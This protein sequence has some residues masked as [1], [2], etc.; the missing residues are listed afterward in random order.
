[1]QETYGGEFD[2]T[3]KTRLESGHQLFKIDID[4]AWKGLSLDFPL[5]SDR[6]ENICGAIT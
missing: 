5:V 2:T 1:M 3:K 4:Q 6:T